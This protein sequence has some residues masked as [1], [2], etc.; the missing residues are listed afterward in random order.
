MQ[1]ARRYRDLFVKQGDIQAVYLPM[2]MFSLCWAAAFLHALLTWRAGGI[3]LG[4]VD[5]VHGADGHVPLS[6][7]SS[8][9]FLSTWCRWALPGAERILE[10]INVE[11]EL[12]EN[13]QRRDPADPGR[14]DVRAR[15][16]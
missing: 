10:V 16:L 1:N 8:R 4:Q 14:G 3:S 2:L 6:R 13:E 7:R 15:Q 9:S 5:R 12:D 11:T